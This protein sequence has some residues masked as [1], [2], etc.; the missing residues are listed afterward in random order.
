MMKH[1]DLEDY[2]TISALEDI[3]L[4]EYENYV[5]HV[6]GFAF[7]R[8]QPGGNSYWLSH[9]GVKIGWQLLCDLEKFV[10]AW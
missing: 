1:F 6:V 5:N 4:F 9:T 7:N 3:E 2:A 10:V 8:S